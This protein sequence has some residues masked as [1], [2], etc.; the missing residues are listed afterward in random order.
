MKRH[1]CMNPTDNEDENKGKR[2]KNQEVKNHVS[3]SICSL[4]PGP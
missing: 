3:S 4:L 2:E 1:K